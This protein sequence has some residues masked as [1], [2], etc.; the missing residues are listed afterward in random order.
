VG[1]LFN[2]FNLALVDQLRTRELGS[3]GF[4]ISPQASRKRGG[5]SLFVG[6]W[7]RSHQEAVCVVFDGKVMKYTRPDI[8]MLSVTTMAVA[9]L[10]YVL[11]GPMN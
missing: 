9:F 7:G 8:V 4:R 11:F 2:R 5:P 1:C 3:G 10:L 6:S